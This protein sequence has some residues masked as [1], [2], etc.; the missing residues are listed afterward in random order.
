MLNATLAKTKQCAFVLATCYCL[1]FASPGHSQRPPR[2]QTPSRRRGR[3]NC[4]V[5]STSCTRRKSSLCVPLLFLGCKRCAVLKSVQEGKLTS[6][7]RRADQVAAVERK[8]EEAQMAEG[9]L[10][11][12]LIDKSNQ[13]RTRTTLRQY[14]R[15][16]HTYPRGGIVIQAV[17]VFWLTTVH[18]DLLV[19]AA[20]RGAADAHQ[21][22]EGAHRPH[23]QRQLEQDPRAV[24][25]VL[26]DGQYERCVYLFI[27]LEFFPL[28]D[29]DAAR[30]LPDLSASVTHG[31]PTLNNSYLG[32]LSSSLTNSVASVS[33]SP[34]SSWFGG[35]ATRSRGFIKTAA[36]TVACYTHFVRC[37]VVT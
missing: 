5:A 36:G 8:A 13:V 29:T 12:Q 26:V 6:L 37:V 24:I 2:R 10:R 28:I 15:L 3:R 18:A 27:C 1:T 4:A 33:S 14:C 25:H 21:G 20:Q 31:S 9:A 7:S 19:G 35:S 32:M 11:Q 30:L 22:A 17:M 16:A 34:L 23:G